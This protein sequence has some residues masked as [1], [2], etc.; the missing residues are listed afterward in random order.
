MPH[1]L[2]KG[3]FESPPRGRCQRTKAVG[4]FTWF[5]MRGRSSRQ[6]F[7]RRSLKRIRHFSEGFGGQRRPDRGD[8][9]AQPSRA[10]CSPREAQ[11]SG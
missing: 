7:M 6:A 11:S 9:Q 4:R 5:E 3:H 8:V 1:P 10:N 2:K